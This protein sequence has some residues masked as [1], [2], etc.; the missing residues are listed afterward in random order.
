MEMIEMIYKF[1]INYLSRKVLS[2]LHY[3]I[4]RIRLYGY[5][6]IFCL[7]LQY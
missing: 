2:Q 6:I 1:K 5:N 3:F 4:K 7:S